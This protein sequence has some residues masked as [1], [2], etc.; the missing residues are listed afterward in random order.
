M[1]AQRAPATSPSLRRG[2]IT[3]C[4]MMATIMQALDTTIAN[5]A[6]PYMQGTLSATLDQVSWVLTSYIVAAAIM[7]APVGWLAGNFGIKKVLVVCAAG[8]TVASMLCGIAQSIEEIVLY[9]LLQGLFGAALVPLSQA[10]MLNI[11][12]IERRG[13]AMSIWGMG[14]MIGPIMGPTLGGWL[15]EYYS[16][17]WVF[18][19]NLPFGIATVLGLLAFMDETE[20]RRSSQFDWFG[21]ASL[22]VAIGSLQLMLDRGEQL[23]WFDSNE[24]VLEAVVAATGFYFFVAHSLTVPR[25]FISIEIFRDRNFVVGL[26]FMFV[27]G[28]LLLASAALMAPFLQGVMGYPILDAG[29]LLGTRGIGMMMAMLVAGRLIMRLGPRTLLFVGLACSTVS[30]YYSIDFSPETPVRTIV[31]TSI[32]QGI[33]LGFMFVPLNTVALSTLPPALRTEGTAMW[34]LIRNLGSS[35]GVSIV[36]AQLTNKTILMHARLAESVTPFNQA[37]AEPTAA[38]LDPSTDTGRALLEQLMTQQATIMAYANDFKLMMLM[39]LAAM[40]LI[41]LIH[42]QRAPTPPPAEPAASTH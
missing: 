24:I 33:G 8:F 11:Y 13:W 12:P 25:P 27:C 30:L 21:F 35:I 40:P 5:V 39:S 41:L 6:L 29:W 20:P 34:T 2:M 23:G 19:I 4:V 38:M 16:W 14:V 32:V 9:R 36:I 7:T 15:T 22:A 37:L 17:R 18:F 28:V 3:V 31:W 42:T 26:L 1:I 10:V